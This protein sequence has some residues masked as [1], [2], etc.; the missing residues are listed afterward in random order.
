MPQD[1]ALAPVLLAPIPIAEL[2]R[3]HIVTRLQSKLPTLPL[4]TTGHFAEL[5]LFDGPLRDLWL[6]VFFE[7]S[8]LVA[9]LASFAVSTQDGC[10][11]EQGAWSEEEPSMTAQPLAVWAVTQA[12]SQDSS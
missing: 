3:P 9:L 1:Y 11:G 6:L 2:C 4:T 5:P 10:G 12:F 8:A 7:T